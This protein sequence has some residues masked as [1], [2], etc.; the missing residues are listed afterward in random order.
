LLTLGYFCT[1]TSAYGFNFWFPTIIKRLSGYTNLEVSLI[2]ALPY[3][4]GL[5]AMLIVGWSSD[6]A[7]ERRWH[8]S[9]SLLAVCLGLLSGALA[10]ENIVLA[11]SMFCIACA[12]LYSYLPG[13]WALPGTFLTEASAAVSIGFINSVGNLGGFFGPAIVGYL[14]NKTGSFYS[15]IIYLSCSALAG[16]ILILMVKHSPTTSQ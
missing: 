3:L 5:I 14:D 10:R 8:T 1:V 16:A 11:V 4:A 6:R 2:S 9:L 13:F 12:G 15:G 7:R